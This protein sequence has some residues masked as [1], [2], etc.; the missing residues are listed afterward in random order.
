[1]AG[2]IN[3]IVLKSRAEY[4][5]KPD[6]DGTERI[7][8]NATQFI[9]PAVIADYVGKMLG[10]SAGQYLPLKG[11]TLAGKLTLKAGLAF[12]DNGSQITEDGGKMS[13]YAPLGVNI[14]AGLTVNKQA[15]LTAATDLL[16]AIGDSKLQSKTDSFGYGR[17]PVVTKL[18]LTEDFIVPLCE[19]E[20]VE[21]DYYLTIE[22]TAYTIT[23]QDGI[24]WCSGETPTDL[25][26]Y[27]TVAVSVIND[28]A[29]FFLGGVF[30]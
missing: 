30:S 11:G 7:V 19:E 25:P 29:V 6:A 28:L 26:P 20:D 5:L 1:M 22:D 12:G 2:N 3:N 9:T 4:L 21:Y 24:M 18:T 13:I 14:A 27:C 16:A 8:V 15:V 17:A 10:L 23:G